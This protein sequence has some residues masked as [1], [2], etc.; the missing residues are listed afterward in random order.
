MKQRIILLTILLIS[1]IGLAKAQFYSVSANAV[2]LATGT[3][4]TEASMTINRNW[5]LHAD[6]S[7][8][9]WRIEKFRIQHLMIRPQVRWW[10]TESYR[11]FFIGAHTLFAGYHFGIPKYMS[12]KYKG[13]AFGAG[14]DIG[15]SWPISTQWNIEAQLGGGWV[16]ADY[17]KLECRNCGEL[18]DS[19]SRHLFL[20][21][22]VGVSLVYLF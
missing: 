21:T 14:L 10:A 20:P 18:R 22:K 19:Q 8:N 2:A 5:S 15:W 17:D 7:L 6:V 11:G 1:S 13:V 9:P 4:N 16:Y 12:N 3:I